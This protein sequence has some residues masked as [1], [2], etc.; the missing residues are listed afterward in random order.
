MIETPKALSM[1]WNDWE[2]WLIARGEPRYRADQITSWLWKRRVKDPSEMTD[3]SKKLREELVGGVDF[4]MLEMIKEEKAADGTRKFLWLLS[5]GN[6]IESALLK[7]GNR[8]TS[9]ISTQVGCPLN[10]PFCATGKAG[11]IRNLSVDEIVGQFIGTEIHVK[12]EVNNLVYMGMGEPL[13]N[14]EGVFESIRLLNAAKLRQLGI[15]HITL[16][17]SGVVPGILELASL[18]P[19]P[20][21]AVSIHSANNEIRDNLVPINRSY[22]LEEL[23]DAMHFFQEQT[24]DRITICYTLFDGL[25]DSVDDARLLVRYLRGLHVYVNLIPYNETSDRFKRSSPENI[26]KFKSVLQTA[27]FEVEVR[28]ERGIEVNA[29]CGQLRNNHKAI[30]SPIEQTQNLPS[31]APS[32]VNKDRHKGSGKEGGP[33][34]R[35][36]KSQFSKKSSKPGR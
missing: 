5:D 31:T 11:F 17:T 36:N 14:T 13:L 6:T 22:S 25:N 24:G 27:G 10:C 30:S 2:N 23:M 1:S 12:R 28:V 15:R 21:L 4:S 18:S 34:S 19:T 26:Q 35:S 8:L 32:P 29:A 20:R 9:C 7:Q 33:F 16:S 3:L